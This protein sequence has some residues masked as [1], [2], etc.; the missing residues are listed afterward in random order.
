MASTVSTGHDGG[1]GEDGGAQ[2]EGHSAR[3][4]EAI[5]RSTTSRTVPTTA[6]PHD[7]RTPFRKELEAGEGE[8]PLQ[9]HR[10]EPAPTLSDPQPQR[11]LN[12]RALPVPRSEPCSESVIPHSRV[13]IMTS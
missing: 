7:L 11:T 4:P 9:Q 13:I 5:L 6:P 8:P 1:G 2:P 3:G 12:P 10:A